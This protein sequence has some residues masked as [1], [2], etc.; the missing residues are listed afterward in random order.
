MTRAGRES[1]NPAVSLRTNGR[2]TLTRLAPLAWVPIAAI[3][4]VGFVFMVL[5][6]TTE[7]GRGTDALGTTTVLIMAFTLLPIGALVARR[8]PENPIGWVFTATS[9]FFALG[10]TAYEYAL[11]SYVVRPGTPGFEVAAW[12]EAWFWFPAL[13][14]PFTLLLLLFPDGRPPSRRWRPLLWIILAALV[15]G[16]AAAALTAGTLNGIE[17]ADIDNPLGVDGAQIVSVVAMAVLGIAAI[18]SFTSLVVRLRRASGREREQLRFVVRA[19]AVSIALVIAAFAIP[20]DDWSWPVLVVAI[21]GIPVATGVAV[22][23]HQLWDIDVIVRKTL[24]YGAVSALLAG[25]YFGIVIGLQ[26]AFGGL[27]RGNDLAI[28]GSTLA[29]AALFRPVR[30]RIQAFVDRRFYR[31]RYDAEQ[32]LASFSA[33][34]RDEVDLDTARRRP[35]RRRP[36][37]DAALTRLAVAARPGDASVS[38]QAQRRVAVTTCAVALVIGAAGIVLE[39]LCWSRG[40]LTANIGFDLAL[41]PVLAIAGLLGLSIV[42]RRPGNPIG[43]IFILF[44]LLAGVLVFAD[45]YATYGLIAVPGSLPHVDALRLAHELALGSAVVLG[46]GAVAAR[47]P[48]RKPLVASLALAASPCPLPDGGAQR[49]PRLYTGEARGLRHPKPVRA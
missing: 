3:I 39:I 25:L 12:I 10:F 26:A 30:A 32:T 29:V 28:A 27:A 5:S 38:P 6:L 24:V 22:I 49:W 11:Y 19:F 40:S 31:R 18:L 15:I 1:E 34:L 16:T 35:R 42:R 46:S 4:V 14:M 21:A 33:R 44:S 7:A 23:R 2:S 36:G 43:W 20:S 17:F 13:V 48:G 37:D 41:T 45:G 8:Q 47:L 9:L